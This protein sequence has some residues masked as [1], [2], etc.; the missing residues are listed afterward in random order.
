MTAKKVNRC[1]MPDCTNPVKYKRMGVCH[2]CYQFL[3]YW[4]K[5]SPAH[6]MRRVRAVEKARKRMEILMPANVTTARRKRA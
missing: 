4:Q 5:K 6:V 2:A 1:S 3:Y